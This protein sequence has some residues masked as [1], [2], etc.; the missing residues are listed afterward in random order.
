VNKFEQ[1]IK[2][3]FQQKRSPKEKSPACPTTHKE[4]SQGYVNDEKINLYRFCTAFH[5][6]FLEAWKK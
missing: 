3:P 6:L 5:R 4:Y 2:T 1:L